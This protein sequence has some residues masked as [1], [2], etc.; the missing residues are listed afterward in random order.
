MTK[1]EFNV[2]EHCGARDG[3]AGNLISSASLMNGAH[4]C[5][6]CR[7]T[8]KSGDFV[9]HAHLKRTDEELKKT[10]LLMQLSL[11]STVTR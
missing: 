7:D 3:R 9:V 11:K 1:M 5:M 6:N 4:L 10:S 8:A 2:C